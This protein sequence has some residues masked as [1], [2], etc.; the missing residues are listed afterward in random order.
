MEESTDTTKTAVNYY[1]A[2]DFVI[3]SEFEFPE[4]P[5]IDS[6]EANPD[7]TIHSGTVEPVTKSATTSEI[8]RID[9]RPGICR[10][11]Y[12]SIGSFL[13]RDGER[14]VVDVVSYDVT[15]KKIFRRL[16]QNELIAVLLT[17]RGLLVLHAS[18]VSIEGKA[19]IFLGDRG[20]GK[21]TTAAAFHIHG[22]PVLEDDTVAVRFDDGFPVVVPGIP[23][24]RLSPDAVTALKFK[25]TTTPTGD[26]GPIKQYLD[27]GTTPGPTP[28]AA[29]YVLQDGENLEF[30]QIPPRNQPFVL[31]TSTYAQ[32]LLRDTGMSSAHFEQCATIVKSSEIK[33]LVRPRD[34]AQLPSLVKLVSENIVNSDIY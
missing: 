12:D 3:E 5:E 33:R 21:S 19:V 30:K 18:V 9:A 7:I 13:I 22:Y 32:G 1:S 15:E 29:C 10:V 16:L 14:I 31:V 24:L 17:Q 20:A 25:K 11:T 28:L 4:V 26:W 23:Q 8:R 27:V 6:R 34:H 2:Y